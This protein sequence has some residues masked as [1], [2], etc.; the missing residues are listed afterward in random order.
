MVEENKRQ[1]CVFQEA[2]KKA[3]PWLWWAFA[4]GYAS[5]CTMANGKFSDRS[6]AEE[7]AQ[8]AGLDF[9]AIEACMGDSSK[10]EAHPLLEVGA[11]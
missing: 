8:A 4:A 10:D 5:H 9:G 2:V 3:E 1:L 7:Q 11:L 6:C